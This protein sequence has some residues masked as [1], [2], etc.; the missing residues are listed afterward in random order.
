MKFLKNWHLSHLTKLNSFTFFVADEVEEDGD[1]DHSADIIPTTINSTTPV[2]TPNYSPSFISRETTPTPSIFRNDSYS[3]RDRTLPRTPSIVVTPTPDDP[4]QMPFYLSTP[5]V[6]VVVARDMAP[7]KSLSEK[8]ANYSNCEIQNNSTSHEKVYMG[9]DNKFSQGSSSEEEEDETEERHGLRSIRSVSDIKVYDH[10]CASPGYIVEEAETAESASDE[11]DEEEE[12]EEDM[13]V[14]EGIDPHQLSVI[15]EESDKTKSNNHSRSSSTS[16]D[17]STTLANDDD[18]EEQS[19]ADGD[20][21]M[22]NSVTVRLPLKLS[23]SR[24]SNNEEIT[25]VVVG[26]SET[27]EVTNSDENA[28]YV[29]RPVLKLQPTISDTDVSVSF[30]VPSRSSSVSRTNCQDKDESDAEDEVSVSVSLPMMRNKFAHQ[31]LSLDTENNDNDSL[32]SD[33]ECEETSSEGEEE[34]Q[35]EEEQMIDIWGEASPLPVR[36][37]IIHQ[38][39][40][41]EEV[42]EDTLTEDSEST[43]ESSEEVE[44]I[45]SKYK[46][47][48]K[49]KCEIRNVTNNLQLHPSHSQMAHLPRAL[50]AE[51]SYHQEPDPELSTASPVYDRSQRCRAV[52]PMRPITPQLPHSASRPTQSEM[53]SIHNRLR[54]ITPIRSMT[55]VRDAT[56]KTTDKENE[57]K[58]NVRQRIAVFERIKSQDFSTDRP[59]SPLALSSSTQSTPRNSFIRANEESAD[60]ED[61][62]VTSDHSR[63]ISDSECENFPELRKMTRYQRAATHSRLFKLLQEECL[64][65]GEEEETAVTNKKTYN[66]KKI[67]HNVSITRRQNPNASKEAETLEQRR[68]RLS[69]PLGHNRSLDQDSIPSTSSG[70]SASPTNPPVSDKLI[71]EFIQSFMKKQKHKLM[72]NV[73]MDRIH[74]AARKAL[75][76]DLDFDSVIGGSSQEVSTVS[77]TPAITPQEFKNGYSDYYDSFNRTNSTDSDTDRRSTSSD[78]S[79]LGQKR[80]WSVKCPRVLSSKTVNR[81]LSLIRE[82]ESPEPTAAVAFRRSVTPNHH[83]SPRYNPFHR[84]SYNN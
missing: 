39:P 36:R 6:V 82:S 3:S 21:D 11:E 46:N 73:S 71:D 53:E 27:K 50:T 45:E 56:P 78:L 62:G 75:Q 74:A 28:N 44:K 17:C 18:D 64:D 72:R 66:P 25:T 1:E 81:D 5:D 16:T 34:E 30:N 57:E 32:D 8:L 60:E 15:Q 68:E 48:K 4:N 31:S 40:V 29:N 49:I 43:E 67:V 61:S 19:D 77:S 76:E 51:L 10:D 7:F 12:E 26:N 20:A 42:E 80:M 2:L 55:P 79:S 69:L 70:S 47:V 52:T 24:S 35:E 38:P 37:Q 54:C 22:E 83:Q 41:R 84:H 14:D 33:T 23:F 9:D 65:E 13:T 63:Q 58:I 59:M